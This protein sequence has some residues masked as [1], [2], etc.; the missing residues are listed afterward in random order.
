[1][2]E[3]AITSLQKESSQRVPNVRRL[4]RCATTLEDE[5]VDENKD[6]EVKH[7]NHH[8]SKMKDFIKIFSNIEAKTN[9]P[10]SK[11]E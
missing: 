3:T 4:E 2:K 9:P 8:S 10:K 5:L 11:R 1:M 6:E 7:F